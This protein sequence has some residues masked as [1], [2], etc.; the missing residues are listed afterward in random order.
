MI[1]LAVLLCISGTIHVIG[2]SQVR[3]THDILDS[4][5]LRNESLLSEKLSIEKSADRFKQEMQL[6]TNANASL[7]AEL[8]RLREIVRVNKE[9]AKRLA[10]ERN[11]T[12]KTNARLQKQID[13]LTTQISVMESNAV[14]EKCRLQDSIRYLIEFSETLSAELNGKISQ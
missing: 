4:E 13:S 12:N 2:L 1:V 11:N 14:K 7:E 10:L 9:Q 3:I 8:E 5:R 6:I